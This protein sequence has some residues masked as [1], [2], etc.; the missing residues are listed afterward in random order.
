ME[1]LTSWLDTKRS[2]SRVLE[3][4]KV[5]PTSTDLFLSDEVN[6]RFLEFHRDITEECGSAD[7]QHSWAAIEKPT[8]IFFYGPYF[9]D[10]SRHEHSEDAVVRQTQELLEA[11]AAPAGWK[12]YIF[13]QNSPCLN[14]AGEPC[15]LKLAR[16]ALEW[17]NEKG[18]KT[19]V[20][21]LNCWGFRGFKEDAFK[22][23]NDSHLVSMDQSRD[24]ESYVKE[25]EKMARPLCE[26]LFS[27]VK[28]VRRP[29]TSPVIKPA[30]GGSVPRGVDAAGRAAAPPERGPASAKEEKNAEVIR[31]ELTQLFN[32]AAVR[33]FS[34]DVATFRHLQIGKVRFPKRD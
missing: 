27:A 12:I 34:S 25:M 33:L 30:E 17:W 20:G 22:N 24:Y 31:E 16:E 6:E 32:R 15:M 28:R 29:L 2:K 4:L 23:L 9:P 3:H 19:H 26:S 21:Y 7:K 13:T 14:R 1:V 18:V 8:E 5:E 11:D 10:Q